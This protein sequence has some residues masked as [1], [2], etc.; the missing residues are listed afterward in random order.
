MGSARA[1]LH[2]RAA[3]KGLAA[4]LRLSDGRNGPGHFAV[5]PAVEA[6]EARPKHCPAP[7]RHH[8]APR[9]STRRS[10]RPPSTP[11]RKPAP[12]SLRP[13]PPR[14]PPPAAHPPRRVD[15]NRDPH[16]AR[17][18]T[19]DARPD[20]R[21]AQGARVHPKRPP[22]Q[23]P[24][25][26]RRPR[27]AHPRRARAAGV[28]PV[29]PTRVAATHPGVHPERL[30]RAAAPPEGRPPPSTLGR[31]SAWGSTPTEDPRTGHRPG[32]DPHLSDCPT[33]VRHPDD[34]VQDAFVPAWVRGAPDGL[35]Q[36]HTLE[37]AQWLAPAWPTGS[38]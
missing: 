28:D 9:G 12:R 18:P 31:G 26:R 4:E 11:T 32:V 2:F 13:R 37:P 19:V 3:P 34:P 33:P 27:H 35:R 10:P 30:T 29:H 1:R 7:R 21:R 14:R 23:R 8:G 20:P 17:P 15:R 24:P 6:D 22:A 25:P 16:A 38:T 36:H 5:Q